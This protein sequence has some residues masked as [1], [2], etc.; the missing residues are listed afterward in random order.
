MWEQKWL[1][2]AYEGGGSWNLQLE[3]PLGA[4]PASRIAAFVSAANASSS[5][6][7]PSSG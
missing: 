2:E 5:C 6:N 4:G 1:K 7:D 3:R